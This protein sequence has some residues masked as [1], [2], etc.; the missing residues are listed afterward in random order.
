MD[1]SQKP[2]NSEC[3]TPPSEPFRIYF[4]KIFLQTLQFVFKSHK[5]NGHFTYGRNCVAMLFWAQVADFLLE[6]K[7]FQMKIIKQTQNIIFQHPAALW[8]STDKHNKMFQTV[9]CAVIIIIFT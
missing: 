1:K 2:S 5:N 6:R 3:Y 7:L 9:F 8:N 4:T